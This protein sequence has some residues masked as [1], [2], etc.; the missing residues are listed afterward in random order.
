V[1][2]TK[3]V[4]VAG[5][6]LAGVIMSVSTA[7]ASSPCPGNS[8]NGLPPQVNSGLP[9][10]PGAPDHSTCPPSHPS[11]MKSSRGQNGNCDPSCT[12]DP[13]N[14]GLTS[15]NRG[16]GSKDEYC[17]PCDSKGISALPVSGSLFQ[18]NQKCSPCAPPVSPCPPRH[19]P[20]PQGSDRN[21]CPPKGHG[22]PGRNPCQPGR[23]QYG[24]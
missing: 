2:F 22:D 6:S 5:L 8:G 7:F 19:N 20:C 14:S 12:K 11:D 24:R 1:K 16:D 17:Q 9:S 18:V 15:D 10:F 4:T 13:Q 23:G 3:L 21:P